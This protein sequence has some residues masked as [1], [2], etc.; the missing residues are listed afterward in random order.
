MNLYGE[1][2]THLSPDW[3]VPMLESGINTGPQDTG[4]QSPPS[5]LRMGDTVF[6]ETSVHFTT[7]TWLLSRKASQN[8]N[9]REN[10]NTFIITLYG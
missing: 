5:I 3:L 1:D 6:L 4:C 2:T 9:R 10:L 8:L 7:L